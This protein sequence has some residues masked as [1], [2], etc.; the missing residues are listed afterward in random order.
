MSLI[1][2][3]SAAVGKSSVTIRVCF[4]PQNKKNILKIIKNIWREKSSSSEIFSKKTLKFV[5][6]EFAENYDPVC[7]KY[8]FCVRWLSST[9]YLS[10]KRRYKTFIKRK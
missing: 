8:S 4:H 3:G 7:I 6:G 10:L 5:V 1:L 2:V 9:N